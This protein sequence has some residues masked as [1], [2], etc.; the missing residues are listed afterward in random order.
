MQ[1]PRCGSTNVFVLQK[2]TGSG[3]NWCVGIFMMLIFNIWALLC[4]FCCGN[5]KTYTFIECHNC[6]A[7]TRI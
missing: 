4:G 3:Y 6:G 7:R 1:C 2:Q 5:K